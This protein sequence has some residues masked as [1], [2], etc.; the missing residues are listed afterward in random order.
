MATDPI[1]QSP[2]RVAPHSGVR[3][4][5]AVRAGRFSDLLSRLWLKRLLFVSADLAAIVASHHFSELL[6]QRSMHLPTVF[7]NP[8]EYYLFYAPFFLLLFA[9]FG[10]YG[11][12][13]LR[14]PEKELELL[15]K[16]VSFSFIAL[17]CANFVLFKSLGFSRYLLLGWYV[18]ALAFVL[19]ERF[20][21]RGFYAEL[22]RRGMARRKAL[23]FGAPDQLADFQTRLAVQR[24][25]GYAVAGA[26]VDSGGSSFADA[27]QPAWPVLGSMDDWERGPRAARVQLAILHLPVSSPETGARVQRIIRR[28]QQQGIEV[29]IYSHFLGSSHLRFQRDEFSGC[30]RVEPAPRWSRALQRAAKAAM[31]VLAGLLGSAVTLA[32]VPVLGLLIKCEDGGP[33]FHR[34]EYLGTDGRIH[35]FLK[36]RTMVENAE[37]ILENDSALKARFA[38]NLKLPDDP[39]VLRCGRFL[40]KYSLDEF[41]Q[42]FSVLAGSITLVGPRAITPEARER[43]GDRAAKL[44]SVK[45]GLTGFWQVMGRQTTTYEEKIQMDMFY[46]DHWSIWLDLVI[47]AKT[48]W[49]VFR[50]EGAY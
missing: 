22:W 39:R 34:R 19:A 49:Q 1:L 43:Y 15:F 4:S 8:P 9:L 40:R 12:P 18:L 45:P 20:A 41:P 32:L 38:R 25:R 37:E 42:F 50:A 47:V 30:F 36:F 3:T 16:G 5:L 31:D 11:N 29:E 28:C 10:A 14:R 26:Y 21:V 44:L 48:V 24:Y 17:A 33:I 13:D 35:H 27:N 7:L 6:M 2:V 23:L 46:I